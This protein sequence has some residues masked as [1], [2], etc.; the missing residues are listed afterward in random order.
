M[1]RA[2]YGPAYT[3]ASAGREQ[4]TEGGISGNPGGSRC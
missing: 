2:G 1:L 3:G 4:K